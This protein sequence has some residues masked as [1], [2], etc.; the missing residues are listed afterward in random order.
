M[1]GLKLERG[2]ERPGICRFLLGF[3]ICLLGSLGFFVG[4]SWVFEGRL[5]VPL[6]TY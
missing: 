3:L 4:F 5:R 6:Q 1:P 2:G